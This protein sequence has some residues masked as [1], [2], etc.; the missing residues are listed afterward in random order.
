[1]CHLALKVKPQVTVCSSPSIREVV[2]VELE[3]HKNRT[4][5]VIL[6]DFGA[7]YSILKPLSPLLRNVG[8]VSKITLPSKQRF[9]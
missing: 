3:F 7:A 4:S 6:D 1:M 5:H 8:S 2:A 9:F